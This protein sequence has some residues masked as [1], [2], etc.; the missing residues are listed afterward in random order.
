MFGAFLVAVDKLVDLF[1]LAHLTFV[2]AELVWRKLGKNVKKR[3]AALFQFLK[4]FLCVASRLR[5]SPRLD[6]ILDL[7]PISLEHMERLQKPELLILGPATVFQLIFLRL[8][9]SAISV[10]LLDDLVKFVYLTTFRR[11][12][13]VRHSL[14]K[15]IGRIAIGRH[16]QI[17]LI[18]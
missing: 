6:V 3:N 10:Y 8:A 7:S 13:L 11:R 15:R 1:V 14:L 2:T 17:L 16:R 9:S 4:E 18:V 5:R 12:D